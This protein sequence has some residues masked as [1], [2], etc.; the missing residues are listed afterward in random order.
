MPMTKDQIL[1][2][3]MKLE[4]EEKEQL[5]D[6]F[7]RVAHGATREEIEAEWAVEIRRRVDALER[8]EVETIPSDEVVARLRNKKAS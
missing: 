1:A 7:W 4:P 2:E 6:A 8:G 5:A 3:A